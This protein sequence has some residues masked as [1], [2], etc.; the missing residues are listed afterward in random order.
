M[1]PILVVATSTSD[2]AKAGYRTGLWLSEL[3]HFVDAV[4]DAGR[5]VE[6]VSIAGGQI[7]LDPE[8]LKT[9]ML[10]QGGTAKRYRDRGYM[11]QLRDTRS[12][13]EVNADDYD[14][15]YLTGGHGVMFDFPDALAGLVGEFAA[16]DKVVSAVCHGP[17]GLLNAQVDGKPLLQG[18]N[19]TGYSWLEEQAVRRSS[20]VPFSLQDELARRGGSYSK[21]RVPMMEHVVV[22]GKLVTGQNPTSAKGVAKAVLGLL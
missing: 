4:R 6:I 22:D 11:D 12:I 10:L 17:A 1:K 5:E 2:Y 14:A 21:A 9:P 19:V 20:V 15:I 13:V 16:Q 7:P 8:S 18:K 3:T